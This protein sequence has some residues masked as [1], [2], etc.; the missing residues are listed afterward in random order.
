M[1]QNRATTIW[2]AWCMRTTVTLGD[3]VMQELLDATGTSN[4]TQAVS[5]A[6]SEYLRRQ[7]L[8]K[9][10]ALRGKIDILSNDEIEAAELRELEDEGA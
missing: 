6:V 9:L 5:T 1:V 8:E 10:R 3:E 2:Y 4:M 7:R